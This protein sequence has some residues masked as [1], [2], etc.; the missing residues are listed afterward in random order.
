M[1][2][3]MLM[4]MLSPVVVLAQSTDKQFVIN[5]TVAGIAENSRI[6]V[7]DANKI[8]DT[9]ASA[10]VNKGS[11]V[12]K[13]SIQEPNLYNINFHDSKKKALLFLGSDQVIISGDI[14]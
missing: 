5:G 10:V 8:E 12:L 1:K 11:F 7:S 6:T 4:V 14:N 3:L 13:G 9:V 2:K